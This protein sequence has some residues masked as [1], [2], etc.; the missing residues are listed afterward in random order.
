ANDVPAAVLVWN[1]HGEN[2]GTHDPREQS[3]WNSEPSAVANDGE[4]RAHREPVRMGVRPEIEA[5]QACPTDGESG[6]VED[7]RPCQSESEHQQTSGAR[8]RE[9]KER[10][11]KVELFLFGERPEMI[12]ARAR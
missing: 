3:F 2:Q 6:A 10:P 12:E 1:K 11:D 4:D 8:E 9:Q 7:Q 5:I